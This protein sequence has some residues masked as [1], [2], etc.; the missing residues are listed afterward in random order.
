MV[1]NSNASSSVK[2]NAKSDAV[3]S[4]MDP[5][6]FMDVPDMPITTAGDRRPPQLGTSQVALR[7][8][9][10]ELLHRQVRS[11]RSEDKTLSATTVVAVT[12]VGDCSIIDTHLYKWSLKMP[13]RLQHGLS[14][15]SSSS[16]TCRASHIRVRLI[17][18][19][20]SEPCDIAC[21]LI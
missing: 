17:W 2:R 11:M 8:I 21:F 4:R 3:P 19:P 18:G 13:G 16:S 7:V 9:S 6:S 1:G 12:S 5:L 20:E 14:S 10:L 15:S